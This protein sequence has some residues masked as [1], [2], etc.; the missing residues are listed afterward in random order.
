M[1]CSELILMFGIAANLDPALVNFLRRYFPDE[2]K[3]KQKLNERMAAI[4]QFGEEYVDARCC[5]M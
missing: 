5:V 1:T 2:V 4:D 3:A